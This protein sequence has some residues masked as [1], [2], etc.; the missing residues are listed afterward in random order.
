MPQ[1]GAGG[2]FARPPG[3]DANRMKKK[4]AV[5]FGGCSP[6][7]EVSLQ[8][9][10]AVLRALDSERYERVM[11]GI[12]RS[13]TWFCYEGEIYRIPAD[14]WKG[15]DCAA[16]TAAL[17][18]ASPSFWK[19]ISGGAE[20]FAVDAA[21]PVLHGKN[22]ED[23]TVPGLFELL[24]VPVVGCGVLASALCMDKARAHALARAAGLAATRDCVLA[25]PRELGRARLLARKI[26]YPLFVKPVRA[27]SSFGV[28]MARS[29]D[30]LPAKVEAAFAYDDRVIVEEAIRG[31]ELGCA[32]L[33]CGETLQVGEPDEIELSGGFF[34]YEEKYTLK[35]SAIH[36]PAR[37]DAETAARVKEAAR[38]VYRALDCR[39]VARADFFL[40]EDGG[41]FFNEANTIPGFTEHSRFPNMMKAAGWTLERVLSAAIEEALER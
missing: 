30:E 5:L 10:Y 6:E 34:D 7:Y 40:T 21:L 36:V 9:A 3:N 15:A 39:G 1:I 17:D 18:R 27:G 41:L 35:T 8:S 26:G 13:G 38:T 32:V 19:W 22:G 4:I 29:A 14:E 23:G 20:R 16:V 12:T 28:G 31:V 11:L 24:G 2:I 37:I 25:S 33:G